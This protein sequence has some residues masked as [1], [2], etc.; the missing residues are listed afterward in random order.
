MDSAPLTIQ[1]IH[2]RRPEFK[3]T[4]IR[5]FITNQR[6]SMILSAGSLWLSKFQ[7]AYSKM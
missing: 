2:C 6:N 3:V 4:A 1:A 5:K 7:N